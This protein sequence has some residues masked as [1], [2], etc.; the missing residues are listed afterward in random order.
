[1]KIMFMGT[2]DFSVGTLEALIEAGH[3][4]VCVVTQPDRPGGR[5]KRMQ[6][7]AVKKA[8]LKYDIPVYQPKR[9]REPEAIEKLASY[10]AELGVV[11]AFGQILPQ[12]LL[13]MPEY[14][15][16]NVHASL[17]PSYRGA[18]PMQWAIIDGQQETG[19]TIMK[20]DAGLD[21]GDIL[22]METTPITEDETA[23]TLHDRLS[24]MG[25]NLLVRTIPDY[26]AG[27][28]T[29]VPQGETTT[30]YASMLKKEMGRIDWTKSAC[31][32]ERLVRGLYPWP[33]AFTFV[34]GKN[35][36]IWSAAACSIDEAAEKGFVPKDTVFDAPVG[37]IAYRDEEHL[38]VM[39]G[40][41]LLFLKE[42]Q[43]EG[44]RRMDIADFLRGT[45]IE[46]FDKGE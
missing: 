27:K 5:G 25:A 6:Y 18:A 31:S 34:N 46:C 20:M 37:E 32:I 2:P 1:M 35:F 7:S 29:P 8:A 40:D 4:I 39:T 3:E 21:T 9:V 42:V 30:K 15:C 22:A 44:K 33:S 11:I 45:K 14:G 38:G 36:K 19:V 16:L 41:G 12:E 26:A 43:I 28:I 23:G 10:G 13:D 24:D 17:L